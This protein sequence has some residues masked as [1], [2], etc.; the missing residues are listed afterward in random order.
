MKKFLHPKPKPR[1]DIFRLKELNTKL[2]LQK[3]R[4]NEIHELQ[5]LEMQ[6]LVDYV[7]TFKDVVLSYSIKIFS[8]NE[9]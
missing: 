4:N 1:I 9:N 2:K 5:D 3:K 8:P 7:R 6:L